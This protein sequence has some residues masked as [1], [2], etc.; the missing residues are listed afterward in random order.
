MAEFVFKR[1]T[2]TAQNS[3]SAG[4][5]KFV[6]PKAKPQ[7]KTNFLPNAP[8]TSATKPGFFEGFKQA[9]PQIKTKEQI[10]EQQ[11]ENRTFLKEAPGKVRKA[12][13]PTPL[14]V[15]DE[16]LKENPDIS[17]ADAYKE[18]GERAFAV[19]VI[20]AGEGSFRDKLQDAIFVDPFFAGSTRRVAGEGLNLTKSLL[21]R[22]V[23]S[24]TAKEV[25]EIII[26][27]VPQITNKNAIKNLARNIANTTDGATIKTQL[28]EAAGS[29]PTKQITSK[30]ATETTQ[31]TPGTAVRKFITRAKQVFPEADLRGSYFTRSTDA[32]ATEARTLVQEN[33]EAALDI[34][35]GPADERSVAVASEYLND[36]ARKVE[37]ATDPKTKAALIEESAS[38]A[39]EIAEKLTELGRG[40]QAASIFNRLTP[41]GQLRAI[42]QDIKKYNRNN[43]GKEVPE[44][45]GEQ[46]GEI[47]QRAK[48]IQAITDPE[49]RAIE[50]NK[51]QRENKKMFIS[52]LLQRIQTIWKA[53]LLTGIKT[54]GLNFFSN[55]SHFLTEGLKQYPATLADVAFSTVTGKRT[56]TTTQRGVLKGLKEGAIKG[57]RYFATGFDE[58][59]IGEKLDY[60]QVNFKSPVFQAYTETVF[61]TLGASDQPWYYAAAARSMMDQA[62]AMGKN[63]GLKGKKLVEFAEKQVQTP[64]DEMYHY[65]AIDATT[66]VFQNKTGLGKI[67]KG[68]QNIPYVGQFIVP[69]AQTPSAVAMQIIN[70]SPIGAVKEA[71]KQI[72]AGKFDQRIMSQAIGRSTIGTIPLYL[73]YKLGEAGL[74]SLDYPAGD[75]RTIELDKAEGKAYNSIKIGDKWRSP[76]VLGPAG[77]LILMGAYFEK[78]INES[79]SPTEAMVNA[80]TGMWESFSEQTFLTGLKGFTDGVTDIKRG[81]INYINNLVASFVPTL[82]SDVARA[83]DPL[84]RSA[85]ASVVSRT[86][87]RIPGLRQVLPEQI[88][89]LGQPIKRKGNVLE[90]MLDPTRP[91]KDVSV[92][93]T[94]ELRRLMDEGYPISPTKLGDRGGYDSLSG[95]ENNRLWQ[96]AGGII[97]DK[98]NMLFT[99]SEYKNATDEERAKVIE[100]L[101]QASQ[102]VARAQMVAELTQGLQGEELTNEL[103][104]HLDSKLLNQTILRIYAEIR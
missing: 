57:K 94:R 82:V 2:A 7:F 39:N 34:I 42:A 61:R 24:R 20:P 73:G 14:E 32:L 3:T 10:Q 79:G 50:W 97:E 87:A 48:E 4:E 72:K 53:G 45:T 83:T 36:L 95:T 81:G 84:E 21:S 64:T 23:K 60:N 77:N 86:F 30:V 85:G 38:I 18:L 49:Q 65:A 101:T 43:P 93:V 15:Y 29:T 89:I 46:A 25:E 69:F 88:N 78:S 58:R 75:E 92:P 99:T 100:A 6:R 59:N 41:E 67:A 27:E 17:D 80:V 103:R 1:P 55:A 37:G 62:L 52:P 54:S 5:F 12:L 33:P 26:K 19:P 74:V 51:F 16:I 66:A 28:T 70:Y 47:L 68:F 44:L 31:R 35:K 71:V 9:V 11:K 8:M 102:N 13:L 56:T 91:S 76:I 96:L 63:L 90:T 98:L 104:K 22:L 40:V